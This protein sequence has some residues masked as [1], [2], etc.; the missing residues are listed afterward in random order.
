LANPFGRARKRI[1]M[2]FC[3]ALF[4]ILILE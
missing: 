4:V 2:Y 3:N 1:A